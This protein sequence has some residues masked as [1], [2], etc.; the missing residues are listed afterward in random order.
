ML[1]GTPE[2][3]ASI[4]RIIIALGRCYI[5]FI[6]GAYHRT[7]TPWD[8]RY[9]SSLIQADTYLRS[10]QRYIERNPVRAAMVDDPGITA[11]SVIA[12]T[13]WGKPIS[14]FPRFRSTLR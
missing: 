5:Q 6:N 3:V 10:C 11:G 1:E 2:H 12:R 13:P 9:R 4:P 7:G 8:S 14:I